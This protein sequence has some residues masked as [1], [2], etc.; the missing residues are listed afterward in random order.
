MAVDVTFE[1]HAVRHDTPI[2][3]SEAR[4]ADGSDPDLS[5][6]RTVPVLE[7]ALSINADGQA[8]VQVFDELWA[9]VMNLCFVGPAALLEN[10]CSAYRY[11]LTSSAEEL[12]VTVVGSQVRLT[13][14]DDADLV[15]DRTALFAALRGCGERFLRLLLALRGP[16]DDTYRHLEPLAARA[17]EVF[18]RHRLV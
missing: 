18:A 8:P 2:E 12:V 5:W 15:C 9:A 11:R 14:L 13:G 16:Q 7:G 10:E 6:L 4:L 1:I 17:G 3:L